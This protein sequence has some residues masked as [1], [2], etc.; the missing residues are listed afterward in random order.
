MS[1][2]RD[3]LIA[4]SYSQV[5]RGIYVWGARGQD[6]SEMRDPYAWILSKE[7]GDEKQAKRAYA[8]YEKRVKQGVKPIR[9]FDCSGFVYWCQD[10]A[11]LGYIRR[12]AEGIYKHQCNSITEDELMSGDLVFHH[13][14][15]KIAH[16]GIYVGDGLVNES[17]GRDVGVVTTHKTYWN[18]FGRFKAL[19][20]DYPTPEPTD[21]VV[22]VKGGS[23]YVRSCGSTACKAIGVAHKGESYPLIGTAATGW[24]HIN[25]NGKDGYISNRADLTEVR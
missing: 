14:G 9:A 5:D 23:V 20:D 6:V 12:S 24:Y 22:Y 17:E 18:R 2:K 21:R 3:K 15:K 8:L 16:V 7:K 13:N 19:A 1:V 11:G 25:F 10:V 4:A